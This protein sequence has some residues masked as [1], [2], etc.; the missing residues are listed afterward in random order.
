MKPNYWDW[1]RELEE[2]R[3]AIS[4]AIESLEAYRQVGAR[5]TETLRGLTRERNDAID[6]LE[7]LER[8]A[9]RG[10]KTGRRKKPPQRSAR[11]NDS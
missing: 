4:E 2:R 7:S 9:G 8:L 1:I 3:G 5:L 10:K 11:S 6:A